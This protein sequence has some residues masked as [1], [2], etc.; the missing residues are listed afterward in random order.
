MATHEV[1]NQPPELEPVNLFGTDRCLREAVQREGQ[2][3]SA[4]GLDRF[5]ALIGTTEWFERGR[6]ANAWAPVLHR[7]D[8]RGRRCDQVEFHPAWHELMAQSVR[9]GIHCGA[10]E[11]AGSHVARQAALYMMVQVEPGHMCP[12][13]MTHAC[14]PTLRMQPE[15]ARE[16]LPR[17][18]TRRYDPRDLPA[19]EKEG[20]TVGMGMTEKQGGTDVRANTTRATPDDVGG[21]GRCYRLTGHKWFFSA[22]MCDLF[23][24]L[25]QAPGG[26]SCFLV[27][28][29]LPDGE[30]NGLQLQRLKDKVGN[31]SNASS[32]VEF[33]QSRGW[34][35]GEEGRG[36]RN[37]IE[38]A[39]GTRL[40]CAVSS[41]GMMR[42]TLL[43]ALH[44]TRHREVFGQA[45]IDQALMRDVLCDLALEVEGDTALAFRLARAFDNADHDETEAAW[46]RLMTPVIKYWNCKRAPGF[47]YEAMECLG[48]NGYVDENVT[49]R[50]YREAPVNAIWEG[51]GNVMCLDVMR[52]LQR[53]PESLD[54]VLADLAPA[55]HHDGRLDAAMTWLERQVAGR[56]LS[57]SGL[58]PFVETLACVAAAALLLEHGPPLIA[59][60]WCRQRLER[61]NALYGGLGNDELM[62]AIIERHLP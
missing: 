55:R 54:A 22:P 33:E 34:L 12:I 53:Q 13:T 60:Q 25:A 20:L 44:H 41:A 11:P 58:R 18:M 29:L 36:V 26:L 14:V 8:A 35:I 48:G 42:Q 45:L 7:F 59:D 6:Q 39:N 47:I 43:R 19:A 62:A 30:H 56:G 61:S 32:E 10:W 27:P 50:L 1:F 49:A 17:L 38:M 57:E 51:S 23:L 4:A 2:A 40:D 52:V 21:P 9:Q 37:I 24:M 46:R 3:D 5:G 15:L 16:F 31:R 28:R